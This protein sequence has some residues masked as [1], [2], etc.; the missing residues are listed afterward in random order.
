[1]TV[2]VAVALILI[3]L[4]VYVRLK[5]VRKFGVEDSVILLAMVYTLALH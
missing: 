3:S 4:R 1:M 2:T 5:I